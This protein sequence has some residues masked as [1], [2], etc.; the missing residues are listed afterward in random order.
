MIKK[1]KIRLQG[2]CNYIF[3]AVQELRREVEKCR[4]QFGI[5]SFS[6]SLSSLLRLPFAM[7]PSSAA[8]AVLLW[9]RRRANF[10]PYF[11]RLFSIMNNILI[12][13]F[14]AFFFRFFFFHFRGSGFGTIAC[15]LNHGFSFV[16]VYGG[17]GVCSMCVCV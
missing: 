14:A 4:K 12:F 7:S 6:F 1:K 5:T 9:P 15:R 11:S 8:L 17:V 16:R 2:G 13:C 10:H 3:V